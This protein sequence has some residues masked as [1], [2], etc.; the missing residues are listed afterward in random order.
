[1]P[2]EQRDALLSN[3]ALMAEEEYTTNRDL[4]DFDAFGEDDLHDTNVEPEK[5]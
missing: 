3:A 1:M 2:R 4:T 5:G